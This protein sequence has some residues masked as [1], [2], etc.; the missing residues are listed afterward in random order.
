MSIWITS[1]THFGHDREFMYGKR[2]F[3]N[4]IDHDEQIVKN[5]NEIIDIDDDVYLLGDCFLNDNIN[6]I[7]RMRQ[8]NGKLHIMIGNHDTKVKIDHYSKL[9]NVVSIGYADI[10][11][12]RKHSFYLSHYPTLTANH[13]DKPT[14]Q[15]LINLCG[16]S[17]TTDKWLHWDLGYCYHC[18]LDAHNNR[19]ISIEEIIKDIKEKRNANQWE[20]S[21]GLYSPH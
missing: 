2:G 12:Y 11:K 21:A 13:D 3:K 17:H 6:G 5:W 19:P 8:L 1:D 20:T 9:F 15:H 16:H 7:N 10:I 18:E 4:I 14:F